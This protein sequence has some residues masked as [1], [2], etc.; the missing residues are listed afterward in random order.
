[1][2]KCVE[3]PVG[4][5]NLNLKNLNLKNRNLKNR[6]LKSRNLKS[7]LSFIWMMSCFSLFMTSSYAQ[8]QMPYI[9]K[10]SGL[11]PF[12]A[13]MEKH[14]VMVSVRIKDSSG[15]ITPAH[16]KLPVGFRI[17]AQ[18][19][20][21]RD[22]HEETDPEGRAFFL[23]IPSNPKV[24]MSI[25]YEVWV[26]YEG[27][28]FPFE[29]EGIP[30][31][32]NKDVL[33]EDFDPKIRL[34]ENQITL[35]VQEPERGL[36]GISVRHEMLE[37]HTDEESLLVIHD[38][39]VKN[40]SGR[41]IDLSH[42]PQGGLKLPTPDG[43]KSPE[44]HQK[45]NE[46]LEIRG[47]AIYYIGAIRPFSQ[48]KI[49]WYYT[50]PY[51][52][53]NFSWSQAMP[54]P[55]SLGLI[56]APRYKKS[57]HQRAFPITLKTINGVGEVKEVSTKPGVNFHSLRISKTFTANEPLQFYVEGLPAPPTWK[58]TVLFSSIG[59]LVFFFLIQIFRGEEGEAHISR[60]HILIE[61]DRLL[62]ALA[63]MEIALNKKRITPQRY[64]REKEMI[65]A[66]L[67]TLYRALEQVDQGL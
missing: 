16:D 4:L 26:D 38:M 63:R 8:M 1:M 35:T 11:P 59:V 27:V 29:L 33:Y 47:T 40:S 42:Q 43:A 67:V 34:P 3:Q 50:I 9:K 21:V 51:R 18:G 2:M 53:E 61:R 23:G 31:T 24:Q 12:F 14:E 52:S 20:K 13:S 60:T 37:F 28:R 41:L 48:R 62:K 32:V 25:T 55:S 49:R 17:L 65:T 56:V 7:I 39:I 19:Q 22:Y 36:E 30:S 54:V 44:L 46:D 10:G 15:K 66:R 5:L 45:H 58:R 57:Q 64:H 6:N